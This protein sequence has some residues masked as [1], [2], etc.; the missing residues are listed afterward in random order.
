MSVAQRMSWASR[1]VTSREEDISYCLLGIF[2]INMP[3]LYGEGEEKAFIRLQMEIIKE[4]SDHSIFAW[5][6]DRPEDEYVEPDAGDGLLATSPVYFSR[7]GN[8]KHRENWGQKPFSMNNIGLALTI[9]LVKL[10]DDEDEYL[11]VLDCCTPMTIQ[12]GE[13][14]VYI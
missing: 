3:I 9:P 4:T 10:P 14:L 13:T 5:T 1:R 2:D 6:L 12:F 8:I 7:C 11:A